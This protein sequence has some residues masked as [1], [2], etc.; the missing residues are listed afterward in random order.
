MP[1]PL[2]SGSSLRQTL[3]VIQYAEAATDL[4]HALR[5]F[6]PRIEHVGSTAVPGLAAKPV[7]DILVGMEKLHEGA[8][9][10]DAMA[11]LNYH[12]RPEFEFEI[13]ERR[14]FRRLNPDGG[15]THHIHM[16]RFGDTFWRRHIAFRDTLRA[17]PETA[18]EYADLK[19]RLAQ[20]YP[21]AGR[22]YTDAKTDFIRGVEAL[23][24]KDVR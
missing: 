20:Q 7:I 21:H 4:A 19:A 23:A 5:A 16:T 14:Y 1:P 6:N 11:G 10:A 2:Q 15:H 8:V 24:L 12:Y 17:H 3:W 9:Y 22:A 13:P 18:Q